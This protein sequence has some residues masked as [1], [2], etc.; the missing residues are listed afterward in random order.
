MTS[1][2]KI[3]Q[4]MRELVSA[5]E[6]DAG[7]CKTP[8]DLQQAAKLG[9]WLLA[10]AN[11]NLGMAITAYANGGSI[12]GPPRGNFARRAAEFLEQ[13]GLQDPDLNDDLA[14]VLQLQRATQFAYKHVIDDTAQA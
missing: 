10:V 11:R 5:V 1:S 7:R 8:E 2:E 13:E 6:E 3:N 12:P 9:R 14:H 4:A